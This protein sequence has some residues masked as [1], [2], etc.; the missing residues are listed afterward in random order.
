MPAFNIT[1]RLKYL[2][3][4]FLGCQQFN[5]FKKACEYDNCC[6]IYEKVGTGKNVDWFILATIDDMEVISEVQG[7]LPND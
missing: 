7:D 5:S 1:P 3:V 2:A 4:N 6:T